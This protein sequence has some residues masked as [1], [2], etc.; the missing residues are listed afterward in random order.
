MSKQ[1]IILTRP[2]PMNDGFAQQIRDRYGAQ[3]IMSSPVTIVSAVSQTSTPQNFTAAIFTS[4]NGVRFAPDGQGPA[5]CVG[6]QTAKD[7]AAKGW[8]VIAANGG[9]KDI[10]DLISNELKDTAAKHRLCHFSGSETTGDLATRLSAQGIKT[11]RCIVYEQSPCALTPDVLGV[12]NQDISAIF[13]I[14]SPNSAKRLVAQLPPNLEASFVAISQAAADQIPKHHI[15]H[16][17]IAH[18]PNAQAML[19]ALGHLL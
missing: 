15:K 19:L 16:L 17:Q 4:R 3:A 1:V 5:F 8:E 7:A 18:A 14:F 6:A 10:V 2:D 9:V 12:L 11:E 13:P